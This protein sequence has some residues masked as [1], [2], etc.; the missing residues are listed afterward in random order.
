[1]IFCIGTLSEKV[2]PLLIFWFSQW[3]KI[4]Y[5]ANSTSRFTIIKR[6]ETE[7]KWIKLLQTP[8]PLGFNDHIYHEG[9]LSKMPDFDVFSLLEFRK[10]TARSHGIKKKGNCKRKS[11]VQKLANCTLRDLATKLDVHGRHCMLSYLSS[12]PI[13]VLRSLDTEANIFYDRL[14]DYMML[15]YLQGV[16]LNMLLVQ[17]LIP[18]LII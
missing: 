17:S 18:K 10:R 16:T 11:R 9:N 14:T 12:L 2:T 7:L 5:D 4:T 6:H 3:K 1:M 8:Y 13:S 15:L